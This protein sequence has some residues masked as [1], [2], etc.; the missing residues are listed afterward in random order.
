MFIPTSSLYSH[1][2][3]GERSHL[4]FIEEETE[5]RGVNPQDHPAERG[6]ANQ[7]LEAS[8]VPQA[9]ASRGTQLAITLSAWGAGGLSPARRPRDSE[10]SVNEV[11]PVP[12]LHAGPVPS[13]RPSPAQQGT[14]RGWASAEGA[15]GIGSLGPAPPAFRPTCSELGAHL[16]CA[17]A[18]GVSSA[19]SRRRSPGRGSGHVTPDL[20]LRAECASSV[21]CPV[22]G[23][24]H[25]RIPE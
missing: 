24:A 1:K 2:N 6:R 16:V 18:W 11:C 17:A 4:H 13:R 3:P 9:R 25:G 21:F 12:W 14:L 23:C 19:P 7:N 5:G 15:P 10:H 20:R 22:L 8:L